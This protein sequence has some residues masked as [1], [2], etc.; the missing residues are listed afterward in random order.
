[1]VQPSYFQIGV[2]HGVEVDLPVPPGVVHDHVDPP[3]QVLAPDEGLLEVG[4]RTNVHV[5]ERD[6]VIS[7]F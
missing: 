7:E 2:D 3:E 4:S 6:S 5:H 1:M